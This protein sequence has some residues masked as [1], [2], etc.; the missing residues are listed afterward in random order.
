MTTERVGREGHETRYSSFSASVP[1]RGRL[2]EEVKVYDED[3]NRR[4]RRKEDFPVYEER[5][6]FPEV[7]LS[8]DR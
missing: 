4:P 2:E 7:E 1:N 3:R 6:R 5:T 8:R